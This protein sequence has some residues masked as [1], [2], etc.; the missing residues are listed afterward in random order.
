[1]NKT[2]KKNMTIELIFLLIM[3]VCTMLFIIT[4]DYVIAEK[5]LLYYLS[6]SIFYTA[7]TIMFWFDFIKQKRAK[8]ITLSNNVSDYK[9]QEAYKIGYRDGYEKAM[10]EQMSGF[11]DDLK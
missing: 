1:M 2:Q 9:K 11:E 7:M 4:F 6:F 5:G 10:D 8:Q 3:T